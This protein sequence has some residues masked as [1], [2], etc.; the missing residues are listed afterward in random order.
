MFLLFLFICEYCFFALFHKPFG[1][2]GRSAY[3]DALYIVGKREVYLL[4]A[5][6]V[7]RVGVLAL[8]LVEEY[9]AIGAFASAYK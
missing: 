9:L 6:D 2:G 7:M 5:F 4:R 1:G 3:S 8:A